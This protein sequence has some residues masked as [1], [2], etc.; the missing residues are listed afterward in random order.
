MA[1]QC[2][3]NDILDWYLETD[4][5]FTG[6]FVCAPSDRIDS[7]GSALFDVVR[8]R[9]S[10]HRI[11]G[12]TV[13]V[14]P[15]TP[16]LALETETGAVLAIGDIFDN[17][18]ATTPEAAL[19]ALTV[20]PDL[21][22]ALAD[23]DLGGRH[24]VFIARG[25]SLRLFHDPFGSRSVHFL[26]G[27]PGYAASHAALLAD[28]CD[29]GFDAEVTTF[30]AS[31]QYRTRVVK[32]LP[33]NLTVFD[34]MRRL[35]PN[36]LLDLGS[37]TMTRFWPAAPRTEG[38]E[39]ALHARFDL[40]L[41]ALRRHVSGRFRPVIALTGGVDTRALLSEFHET[42]EPFVSV[43]WL[44]VNFKGKERGTVNALAEITGNPHHKILRRS[45]EDTERLRAACGFNAGLLRGTGIRGGLMVQLA[46]VLDPSLPPVFI[47][48]YGGEILRGFYHLTRRDEGLPMTA[49]TMLDLYG[50]GSRKAPAT[51]EI[52]GF[53][54]R[55][56]REFQEQVGY[57][58]EAPMGYDTSDLFYWEHRMGMWAA[59]TLETIDPAMHCLVGMNSRKL[60]AAALS[61]P[62][63]QRLSKAVIHRYIEARS[64]ALGAVPV[65]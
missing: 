46:D 49:Q 26:P 51:A 14:A 20:A 52:S 32:Y 58:K 2:Y 60:F 64:P 27:R 18:G 8:R 11:G 12:V 53:V 9:F 36:H 19:R 15:D 37:A 48:G 13:L 17:D 40:A 57:D 65:I 42:R 6:G 28:L 45:G 59:L 34:G 3:G 44:D 1:Q 24:A 50:V 56:F 47:M 54:M 7:G 55:A 10:R 33:G 43:T 30:M 31:A 25:D 22:A 62:N 63:G 29:C 38:T 21:A 16:V 61:L 4:R 23:S 39:A 41:A 5:L 35:V